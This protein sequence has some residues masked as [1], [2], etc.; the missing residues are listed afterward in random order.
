MAGFLQGLLLDR[1]LA[2][3]AGLAAGS[4][5]SRLESTSGSAGIP[6]CS[7]IEKRLQKGWVMETFPLNGWQDTQE[8]ILKQRI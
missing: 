5:A 2:Q 8:G 6:R 7:E 4:A 3:T 1:T